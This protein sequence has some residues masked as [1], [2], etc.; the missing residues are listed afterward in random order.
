M[1]INLTF[2]VLV[3]LI[4]YIIYFICRLLYLVQTGRD[5]VKKRQPLYKKY[6]SKPKY[7]ILCLGD[8]TMVAV[9]VK[10]MHNSLPALFSKE[11]P[12]ASV[13]NNAEV[14]AGVKDLIVQLHK[15]KESH[16]NLILIA[17]GAN[18]IIQLTNST[19]IKNN[20]ISF[21]KVASNKA[22][23]IILTHCPNVGNMRM[24]IFPL[25]FVY[26]WVS[27]KLSKTFLSAASQFLNVFYVNFYRPLNNDFVGSNY[28]DYYAPDLLHPNDK[29]HTFFFNY[30]KQKLKI[31]RD[32]LS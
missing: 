18:D 31:D 3:A 8:S 24:F 21:L 12:D 11:F 10:N 5:I 17:T 26:S 7:K 28:R 16:Y 23:K 6:L 15:A 2:A 25:N 29:F 19:D 14:G 27:K 4:A 20:L 1:V 22:D 9:G 13:E 30:V 32:Y